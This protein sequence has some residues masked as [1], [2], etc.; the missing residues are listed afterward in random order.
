[1]LVVAGGLLGSYVLRRPVWVPVLIGIFLWRAAG[2]DMG[3]GRES[4]LR[5]MT[6][7]RRVLPHGVGPSAQLVARSDTTIRQLLR[8]FRGDRYHLVAVVDAD[9][10]LLGT[11][12]EDDLARAMLS[13]GIEGSLA[14]ALAR[15]Q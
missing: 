9:G 6:K 14:E 10:R 7:A 4:V 12:T 1:M 15:R 2:R 8:R 5:T 13:L 11:M 3:A